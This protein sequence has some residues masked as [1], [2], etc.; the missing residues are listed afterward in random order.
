[1]SKK[2]R[3]TNKELMH[4]ARQEG[5]FKE[6]E[7]MVRVKKKYEFRNSWDG[8]ITVFLFLIAVIIITVVRRYFSL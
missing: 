7:E 4:E 8:L 5:L 3:K 2:Q 1:M 6:A